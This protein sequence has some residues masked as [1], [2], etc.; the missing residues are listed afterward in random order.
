MPSLHK[1]NIIH[2]VQCACSQLYTPVQY[3]TPFYTGHISPWQSDMIFLDQ[4]C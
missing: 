2:S 3:T 4:K 1:C